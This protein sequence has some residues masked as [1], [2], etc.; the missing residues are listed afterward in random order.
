[1]LDIFDPSIANALAGNDLNRAS[2]YILRQLGSIVGLNIIA[3][4]GNTSIH[5]IEFRTRPLDSS[6]FGFEWRGFVGSSNSRD[7]GQLIYGAHMFPIL[8]G[9]RVYLTKSC[10]LETT[11]L[12]AYRYLLL[13]PEHAWR[14]LGWKTD[15]NRE[16]EHWYLE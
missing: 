16:F 5:S 9:H 3:S 10:T 15:S 2:D 7:D 13:T 14:D 8:D 1:M 6:G 11:E 4:D 12:I